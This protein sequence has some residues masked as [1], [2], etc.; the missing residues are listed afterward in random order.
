MNFINRVKTILIERSNQELKKLELKIKEL[1]E[2]LASETETVK[3]L[4]AK[5]E[6]VSKEKSVVQK[7]LRDKKELEDLGIIYDF[8]ANYSQIKRITDRIIETSEQVENF[9]YYDVYIE[10]EE[11]EFNEEMKYRCQLSDVLKNLNIEIEQIISEERVTENRDSEQEISSEKNETTELE[12]KNKLKKGFLSKIF[13]RK[14]KVENQ[15]SKIVQKKE[16]TLFDKYRKTI[17]ELSLYYR[18]FLNVSLD[19]NV[20]E[21]DK[22]TA[23]IIWYNINDIL[24]LQKKG[25]DLVEEDEEYLK[26]IEPH[27]LWRE[28]SK[29]YSNTSVIVNII[30][31]FYANIDRYEMLY[32]ER[33]DLFDIEN[34]ETIFENHDQVVVD[35]KRKNK[36]VTKNMNEF[37]QKKQEE[38]EIRLQLQGLKDKKKIIEERINKIEKAKSLKELGYKSKEDV[39]KKLSITTKDYIVI[40]IPK[41]IK[42]IHELFNDEKQLKVEVDGKVFFTTYSNDIATGY[43]NSIDSE[44]NIDAVLMVPIYDLKKEDIDCI[45]EGKVSLNKSVLQYENL[46]ALVP[47]GR[48]LDFG[49][50]KVKKHR[51]FSKKIGKEIKKFLGDDYSSDLDETENYDIFK[52]ITNLSNKEKRIKREA[53]KKCVLENVRRNVGSTDIIYVNGKTFFINKEDEKEIIEG[54]NLQPLNE[55]RLEQISDE[56]EDYLIGDNRNSIKIDAFYEKLLTEYMRIN[57][58]AKA[59]YYEENNTTVVLNR[60]KY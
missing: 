31:R 38:R 28:I 39:I 22:T 41:N 1:E 35:L 46:L 58:K 32:K 44:Q 13:G 24:S 43:I 2:N 36:N 40:P 54:E 55:E 48:E 45:R 23:N 8:I 26:N 51:F 7:N 18:R 33:P 10:D 25:I 4:K 60:K 9:S 11:D 53:V 14:N 37:S 42:N 47:D 56:I 16:E 59:D 27:E 6:E 5:S 19:G 49:E 29:Y 17:Y 57:K 30:K 34:L 3:I 20:E 15:N 21:I 50:L 12:D 52:G